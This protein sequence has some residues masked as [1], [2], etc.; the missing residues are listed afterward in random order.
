MS[1]KNVNILDKLSFVDV[2]KEK[3]GLRGHVKIS[4]K[5]KE[6][7]EVSLW[8][9]SDNII[10][11]SG[12]QF[13][14]MKMFNL[15]L[16]SPHKK[17]Y[18]NLGRDTNLVIPDLNEPSK[19]NI[20]VMPPSYEVMEDDIAS[21]HFI[22]GFMIGNGGAG[23]D[24]NT[25]KNTDY[26]FIQLRSP[27]AFQQVAESVGLSAGLA[28]KYLGVINTTVSE[29]SSNV[30]SYYIKK[31][32]ER[33]HIVHS[34]WR[35]GQKWDYVDPITKEDLGPDSSTVAK[36]NRIE[37]YAQCNLSISDNDCLSCF[38]HM[39]V[40]PMINELGLVAFD[41]KY[42]ARSIIEQL[43][44]SYIKQILFLLYSNVGKETVE[45]EI[46]QQIKDLCKETLTVLETKIN[47][48]SVAD[49]NNER[50]NTFIR[51]VRSIAN[52]TSKI[53]FESKTAELS[54]ENNI[55]VEAMYNQNRE[56]IYTTDQ[57]LDILAEPEFKTLTTDEAER[58][59]LCTYYTFT[60]IPLEKNIDILIDYR[61]YAN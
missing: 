3:S 26:S 21:N 49:Y 61:I 1:T 56:L 15:Y 36:S 34:W 27:I 19:M 13:I 20:G 50:M 28:N 57:Y 4:L 2:T 6:T 31:F 58:I 46:Q 32:D 41:C 11:I 51:T 5:N 8:E 59:R 42:G 9:E 44:E 12:Y 45:D 48:K 25:T 30:L 52:E 53:N 14:L 55:K 47:G 39:G 24:A 35:D 29:S 38:E 17:S 60:S 33:P 7:G 43:H 18:E 16:D 23:E 40:T 10:P 54:N 22:Q 37:T